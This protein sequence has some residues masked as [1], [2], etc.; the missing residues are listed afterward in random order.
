MTSHRHVDEL[1]IARAYLLEVAEPPAVAVWQLVEE[2]GPIASAQMLQAGD[3]PDA[4]RQEVSHPV[5]H[6]TRDDLER[7]HESGLRLIIPEDPEWPGWPL[8]D[9]RPDAV[10]TIPGSCPPL[11]LWA[12][13]P[14]PLDDALRTAITVTGARAA[15]GYGEYAAA[16]WAYT[17][18]GEG[19][20]TV[21]GA[22]YGVDAAAHRGALAADGRTVAVLACGLGAGY[23][24]GHHALLSK[25]AEQGLLL[26]EYPPGTPPTRQR[27][28]TRA[29]LLAALADAVVV[30][31]A[32]VRSGALTVARTAVSLNRPVMAVPGPITSHNSGGCHELIRVG[33]AQLTASAHDVLEAVKAR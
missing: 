32:G 33:H 7:A 16:D 14:A 29:R 11:A 2:H 26:S 15:S 9:L 12:R 27:F 18:G 13:G 6:V 10:R 5:R 8:T 22:A 20:T 31:E 24:A 23:P 30:I 25:I 4:V 1:R 28:R 3:V 21:S 19:V 17:F